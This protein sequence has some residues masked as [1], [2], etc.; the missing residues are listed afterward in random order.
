[1][2]KQYKQLY[3]G[4]LEGKTVVTPIDS[5]TLSYKD[6]N[7]SLEAVNLIQEKRNGI[8]K[9]RTCADCIEQKRYL[10]EGERISSPTVSLEALF[11]TLIFD[12]HEGREVSTFDTHKS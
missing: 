9:K 12:A 10:K 3:K 11:F 6:K 2:L 4:P 5:D 7:K 1:M 8:I